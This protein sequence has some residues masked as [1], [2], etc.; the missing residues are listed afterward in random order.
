MNKVHIH[1]RIEET[2]KN[3][4]CVSVL[5]V[6]VEPSDESSAIYSTID[7]ARNPAK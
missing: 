2:F 7:I 6:Q 5:L 1:E 4:A 3:P